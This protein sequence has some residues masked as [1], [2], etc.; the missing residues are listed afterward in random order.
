M[1]SPAVTFEPLEPR[2]LLDG[3]VPEYTELSPVRADGA[4][5]EVPTYSVPALC[6]W[7]NDGL[8]DLLVGEL[9]TE[10]CGPCAGDRAYGKVRL[11]LNEGTQS[12]PQFGAHTY[13]Q[14][15]GA[16]LA[17]DAAGCLGAFP[18][19]HDWNGDGAKDLIV[20]LADGSIEVFL[21]TG[22]DDAPTFA[23]SFK[24][25]VGEPGS[26]VNLFAGLRATFDIAD[27]NNDGRWDLVLGN[28]AGEVSVYLNQ[29]T[30]TVPDFRA[31]SVV[32]SG[33]SP[34]VVPSGRSSPVVTDLNGDGKND[35]LVG[36]TDGQ[37]VFYANTDTDAAPA[38]SAGA[39]LEV[40]GAAFDLAGTP[41]S[42]PDAG[43]F[44]ADGGLD[45][46]IGAQDGLVRRIDVR[47]PPWPD[48]TCTVDTS[49]APAGV[50][51]GGKKNGRLKG[52]AAVLTNEGI[53]SV[54]G[55]VRLNVYASA[56]RELQKGTDTLLGTVTVKLKLRPRR[57]KSTRL[58]RLTVP[59]LPAAAYHIVVES[60]A[61]DVVAEVNENNN[62]AGS[63]GTINWLEL[64]RN[65]TGAVGLPNGL[66]RVR[67]GAGKAGQIKK[68]TVEVAN[69]GNIAAAGTIEI[70]FYA[71]ADQTLDKG[72]DTNLGTIR[73]DINVKPGG[74]GRWTLK[75]IVVPVL[76]PG[77]YH[78]LVEVDVLNAIVE[79]N[80]ADNVAASARTIE[81]LA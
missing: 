9:V 65:L 24:V 34:L 75:N 31:A 67:P 56:D 7:N 53:T 52:A 18:R 6:D 47:P 76:P 38:F 58:P 54:V 32:L 41:R 73:I 71:S 48:L 62:N 78:V 33:G 37:L 46:L 69:Q 20:G 5:I 16:T 14:S 17:V 39:L 26:K 4:A 64:Q 40:D 19:A 11:Y 45:I 12:Q 63:A 1:L 60:D 44:D 79:T 59:V 74:S 30:A 72:A 68:L 66:P 2:L 21:N 27:W 57:S 8:T 81:W 35:L 29:G 15:N 50:L 25:Q 13:I 3:T 28:L 80:E 61:T 36:N 42:R 10:Y 43:D 49:K 77:D 70:D 55:R 51:P 22:A 23:G